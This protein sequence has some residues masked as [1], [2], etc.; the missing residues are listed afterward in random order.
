MFPL[1]SSSCSSF[2]EIER[3]FTF[4]PDKTRAESLKKGVKEKG[5]SFSFAFMVDRAQ[6]LSK[7]V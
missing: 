4:N 6:V 7:I 3:S 2:I 5:F 1:H